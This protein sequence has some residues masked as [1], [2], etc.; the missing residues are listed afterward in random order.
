M[1]AR[2]G[3]VAVTAALLLALSATASGASASSGV[4][5]LELNESSGAS[6]AVDSSGHH[7]DGRVG[8][9]VRMGAGQATFPL[10]A[11][12]ASLGSGPLIEVPD[13]A[14]GSL[15][16]GKGTFTITMRYRTTHA[17]GNIVQKGQA[18]SSGGQVKLQQPKGKLTCMFK[19]SSGTATAGSGQ[20][21]MDNGAWHTVQCVRTTSSVTMYVDGK[22]TGRSTHSTGNLDN[23][24]PW[25]IGGK[26][27]CDGTTVTCDYFAGDVDYLRLTKG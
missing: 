23:S 15:D 20:V 14:D 19:T 3:G 16:P 25:T 5:D 1:H 18:T 2:T 6:T 13:A 27:N 22:R 26:P 4:L 24:L 8:N 11:R 9:L 17:F 12:N 10:L 7:H 21:Q